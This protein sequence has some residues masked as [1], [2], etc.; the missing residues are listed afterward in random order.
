MTQNKFQFGQKAV[1]RLAKWF[2]PTP[3]NAFR[4]SGMFHI[5][6]IRDGKIINEFDAANGV[7]NGGLDNIL[8]VAFNAGTQITIWYL[9]LINDPA[10]LAVADT[11]AA[12]AGWTENTAYT[13]ANRITIAFDTAASQ[14]VAN[15]TTSADFSINGAGTIHGVF[16]PS[17]NTKGGST[18]FLWA[19]APFA[20]PLAVTGGD[21][22]EVTY[23]VSGS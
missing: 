9:G 3:K 20:A 10:T 7:T 12:H 1:A 21:L 8:E 23:T 17:I 19:T 11:M 18:G 5:Q 15:G 22:L 6:H 16:V 14:A 4:P 2:A 13:E